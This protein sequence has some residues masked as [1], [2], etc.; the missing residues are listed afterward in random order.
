VLHR[1]GEF[2]EQDLAGRKVGE[3]LDAVDIERLAIERS[4]PSS[5]AA[6]LTSVFL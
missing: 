2:G 3:C 1:T 5:F 4:R 6:S